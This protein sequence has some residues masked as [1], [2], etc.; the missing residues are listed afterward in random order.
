MEKSI[1]RALLHRPSALLFGIES[2]CT[3]HD[4][5]FHANYQ[6]LTMDLWPVSTTHIQYQISVNDIVPPCSCIAYQLSN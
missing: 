3:I 2:G 4:S 5:I 1:Y 6:L